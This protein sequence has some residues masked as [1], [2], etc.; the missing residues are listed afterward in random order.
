MENNQLPTK[1]ELKSYFETGKSP[2]HSQFSDLIDSYW[3]KDEN[4]PAGNTA[5]DLSQKADLTDGKVPASQL[6]SYVD[7]VL[8]FDSFSNLPDQGEKGKIY[9]ATDTKDSYRWSGSVYIRISADP[10]ETLSTVVSRD[11]LVPQQG[12]KFV[13]SGT[14]PANKIELRVNTKTW[15]QWFGNMNPDHTGVYNHSFGFGALQDL[16]TG[17]GNVA[18]GNHALWKLTTGIRNTVVGSS[19]MIALKEGQWNVVVGQATMYNF[20]TGHNNTAIGR[21]ALNN[22]I[23]GY[24]NT[25]LGS[26]AGYVDG[27][28]QHTQEYNY[29]TFVGFRSGYTTDLPNSLKGNNNLVI[30]ANAPIGGHTDNKLVIHSSETVL[31]HNTTLPLIGGDF[32]RRTL[33]FDSSL[34]IHRLPKADAGF[35][36]N[37]V[38]KPDGTLGWEEKSG[39]TGGTDTSKYYTKDQIDAMLEEISGS[40]EIAD[41]PGYDLTLID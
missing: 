34:Q 29:N 7:D 5:Y 41:R 22:F 21:V 9:V 37:I 26:H 25:A 27:G 16:T 19:S 24:G 33:D 30:G 18:I 1:V 3:H 23:G 13:Q 39:S 10:E 32:A 15:S 17:N 38:A 6:P 14:T 12:I 28:T 20:A 36:Q 4:I 31:D 40:G 8:E 2:T 11:N 35:T